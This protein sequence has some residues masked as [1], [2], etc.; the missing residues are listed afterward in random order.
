MLRFVFTTVVVVGKNHNCCCRC[1]CCSAIPYDNVVV[2]VVVLL[3]WSGEVCW[4]HS[5]VTVG[6]LD[7]HQPAFLLQKESKLISR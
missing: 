2:V 5:L 6:D 7:S 1:C 3:D 4:K